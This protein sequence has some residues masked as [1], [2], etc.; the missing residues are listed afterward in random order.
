MAENLQYCGRRQ[1]SKSAD[2]QLSHEELLGSLYVWQTNF[3]LPQLK[4]KGCIQLIP[5]FSCIYWI[6]ILAI[7]SMEGVLR[8]KISQHAGCTI[9]RQGVLIY[10]GCRHKDKM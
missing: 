9:V 8:E 5:E 2:L 4:T 7:Q 6:L 10:E 1:A 3:C